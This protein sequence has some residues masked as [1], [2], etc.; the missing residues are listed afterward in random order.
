VRLLEQLPEGRPLMRE[1]LDVPQ[2]RCTSHWT[3]DK[4]PDTL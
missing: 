3:Q 1:T 2:D 4:P